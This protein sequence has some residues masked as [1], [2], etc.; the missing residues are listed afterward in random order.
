MKLILMM[1][2]LTGCGAFKKEKDIE[3]QD[4]ENCTTTEDGTSVLITCPDGSTTIIKNGENGAP[5]S[6]GKNGT[7]GPA[8]SSGVA[9]SSCTVT[10]TETG[11]TLTCQDGTSSTINHGSGCRIQEREY[12]ADLICGDDIVP[13]RH[14]RNGEAGPGGPGMGRG[15][16]CRGQYLSDSQWWWN[17]DFTATPF[18]EDGWFVFELIEEGHERR[19]GN[20]FT[21]Q[22]SI[23]SKS[24]EMVE[25]TVFGATLSGDQVTFTRL[26]TGGRSHCNLGASK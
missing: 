11:S 26:S 14:G 20:V 17:L 6:P 1:I 25:T 9:G 18:G 8:G 12:G 15:R 21:K 24:L 5:G 23:V 16:H 3:V 19:T 22:N 2:L 13:I 4:G 10:E 7:R